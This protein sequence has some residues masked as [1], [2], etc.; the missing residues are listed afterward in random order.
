MPA[1]RAEGPPAGDERTGVR[2][3]A[4]SARNLLPRLI[5]SLAVGAVAWIW[6]GPLW[7]SVWFAATWMILFAGIGLMRLINAQA[8]PSA[9]A[10]LSTALSLNSLASSSIGAAMSLAIWIRGDELAREFAIISLFIG[11]AYVLL[12]YY[13]RLNTFLTLIAPYALALV[14]IGI[15]TSLAGGDR[16]RIAVA[17]LAGAV[18]LLNFFY[19]S[20]ALLDRSSSALRRARGQARQGETAAAAANAAKTNFLATMSHEIR[21]PLN[22]VLGMAQA[23]AA[24]PLSRRQ[25]ERLTIIDES[26]RTL[27]ALLN[28]ILDLSKIEAGKLELEEIDFDFADLAQGASSAFTALAARKGLGFVVDLDTARGVYHGDP[29][30]LRQILV[31]LIS[32]AVKF[33]DEGEIRITAERTD[34]GLRITVTDTGPGVPPEAIG[35]LFGRFDQGDISTNRRFGGSGLGLAICHQLAALM[36]GEI[37]VESVVGRGCVFTLTAPLARVGEEPIRERSSEVAPGPGALRLDVRVLAA[38][39]NAVNQLVLKTLLQQIGVEPAIVADGAAA[40]ASWEAG[41]WDAILMDIQMP[42]MDGPDAA[43]AI[44]EG[45][46]RTGRRRTPIIALTAN[47]L[48]H[49]VE[50]Y[51]AAGMDDHVAKPIEAAR[52]FDALERA[53]AADA[54][55]PALASRAV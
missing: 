28:D 38:E 22:G 52:L 33:T 44:R 4:A 46:A 8:S 21:T 3:F 9:A 54:V 30:R 53:I 37:A 55:A 25:R 45:E 15:H 40:V 49:Q 51:L 16:V 24:E 27:L 43:R 23:M 48:A 26:G 10:Q 13:A 6:V 20:R 32:N 17:L 29:T 34:S 35:R 18:S 11:G 14:L 2:L 1:S 36:G 50:E 12:H 41:E 39:D 31:N 5:S 7:T 42:V 47:A 19:L